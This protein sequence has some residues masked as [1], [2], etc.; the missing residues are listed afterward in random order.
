MLIQQVSV[1]SLP[2]SYSAVDLQFKF[3]I[4]IIINNNNN[5]SYYF[6]APFMTSTVALQFI[7]HV[8]KFKKNSQKQQELHHQQHDQNKT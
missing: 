1:A 5:N 6:K 4:I 8:K 2:L 3:N 7:K